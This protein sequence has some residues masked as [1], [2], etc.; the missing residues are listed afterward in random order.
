MNVLVGFDLVTEIWLVHLLTACGFV[1]VT[2][3]MIFIVL[4]HDSCIISSRHT[5][6]NTPLCF[7]D[8]GD[9]YATMHKV[10]D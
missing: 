2:S 7:V 10:Y 9:V 3:Y 5:L 1:G 4:T 8:D 6:F